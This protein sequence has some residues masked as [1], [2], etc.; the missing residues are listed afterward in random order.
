MDQKYQFVFFEF[1]G[2]HQKCHAPSIPAS[3]LELD[4]PWHC[5]YCQK[6][7][8]NPYLTESIDVMQSLFGEDED[9]KDDVVIKIE[10]DLE[11]EPESAAYCPPP[12]PVPPVDAIPKKRKVVLCKHGNCVVFTSNCMF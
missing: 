4:S 9:I 2:F 5:L 6:H 10:K 8:K 1:S 11:Y 12:D 3:A 7:T